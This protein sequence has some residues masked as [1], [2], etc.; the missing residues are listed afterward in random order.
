MIA[1]NEKGYCK[2]WMNENYA[3]NSFIRK[4][5]RESKMVSKIINMI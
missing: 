1:I 2:V 5:N 4:D 3:F